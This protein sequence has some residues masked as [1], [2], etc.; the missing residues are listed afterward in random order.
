M[1]KLLKGP[2]GKV[3]RIKQKLDLRW[4]QTQSTDDN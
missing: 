4:F 1:Q 3:K 2:P